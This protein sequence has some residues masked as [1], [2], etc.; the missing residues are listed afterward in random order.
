VLPFYYQTEPVYDDLNFGEIALSV[1]EK[2][3]RLAAISANNEVVLSTTL[4][5][6]PFGSGLEEEQGSGDDGP[7]AFSCQPW[8]GPAST[9]QGVVGLGVVFGT[10]FA[11]IFLGLA[12]L[13]LLGQAA[14][15]VLR[16]E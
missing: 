7:G 5:V 16:P 12:L 15:R 10:G 14:L 3:I 1:D 11:P 9:L 6:V 13:R 8:R 2:T 4:P